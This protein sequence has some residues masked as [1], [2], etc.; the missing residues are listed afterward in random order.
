MRIDIR[1]LSFGVTPTIGEHVRHQVV[2]ALTPVGADRVHA[3]MVWLRDVNGARGGVDK[4]CRIV[5]WLNDRRTVVVEG[6]HRDLY[7]AVESAAAKLRES[8][9]RWLR[10]SRT[11]RR[12]HPG[13]R[14]EFGLRSS[15]FRTAS[16]LRS[17]VAPGSDRDLQ[18]GNGNRG[19]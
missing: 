6:L 3:V 17:D 14:G 1:G 10:R 16:E 12:E 11:L 19:F 18:H 13:R 2:L 15:N 7:L 5:A 4:A 9:R 8:A